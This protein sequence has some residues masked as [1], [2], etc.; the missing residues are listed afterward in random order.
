MSMLNHWTINGSSLNLSLCDLYWCT[1]DKNRSHGH[2]LWRGPSKGTN[3]RR[4]GSSGEG[5]QDTPP[6]WHIPIAY[7][8]LGILFSS[9]WSPICHLS[10]VRPPNVFWVA[11][12]ESMNTSKPCQVVDRL[13]SMYVFLLF[14]VWP[15]KF[16]LSWKLCRFFKPHSCILPGFSS[17]PP[18]M[19]LA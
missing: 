8:I 14:R 19:V 6:K 11:Y 2:T 4:P 1:I 18:Q 13:I 17:C 7:E 16:S 12:W 5:G 3:T 15:L 10:S 9:L